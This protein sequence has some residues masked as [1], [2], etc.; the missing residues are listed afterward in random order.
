MRARQMLAKLG[1]IRTSPARARC[2]DISLLSPADQDRVLELFRKNRNSI[3]GVEP[4]ITQKEFK[5]LLRLIEDLPTL[6]PDDR[7]AGPKIEVPRG[8]ERYWERSQPA[9]GGR[10]YSFRNLGK[11]ETL[12]FVELCNRNGADEHGSGLRLRDRM[13]PLA[14]WQSD[15]KAEMQ[16]MLEKAARRESM[17]IKIW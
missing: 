8:L 5:E 1:G 9:T 11:V 2:P 4:S 12:R 17:A 3:N 6:G 13:V 14:E 15:D 10:G 16:A 7:F